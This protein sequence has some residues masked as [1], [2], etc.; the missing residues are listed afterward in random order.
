MNLNLNRLLCASFVVVAFCA[1]APTRAR[2]QAGDSLEIVIGGGPHAGTY[3]LPGDGT[4]CM[5]MKAQKRFSCAYRDVD[6]K[7]PKTVNS[8]GINIFNPDDPGPK[9]GE[10]NIRFGDPG[11]KRS[12]A[13]GLFI[14]RD[15]KGPLTLTRSGKAA[16]LTFEGQTANGIKLQFT[17]KTASV[18]EF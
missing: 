3:K 9:Q 17:A 8:A 16:T 11:D 5:H 10:V 1:V 15:S 13:Y 4:I 14:P 12:V 6:A 2:A 18:S 7:D